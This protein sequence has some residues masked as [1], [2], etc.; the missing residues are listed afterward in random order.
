MKDDLVRVE[1]AITATASGN[2]TWEHW[3]ID[4]AMALGLAGRSNPLGFAIVRYIDSPSRFTATEV[5]LHLATALVANGY[6]S[7]EANKASWVALE[8]WNSINCPACHGRGVRNIEQAKCP[9]CNGTGKRDHGALQA[10]VRDGIS[11]LVSAEHW[12]EGQLAARLRRG[13]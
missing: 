7:D 10:I 3:P 4:C 1:S 2:L 11:A 13:E 8:A 6:A 9:R 12:L 5:A